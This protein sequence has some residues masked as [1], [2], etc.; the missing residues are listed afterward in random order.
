MSIAWL[1]VLGNGAVGGF[2]TYRLELSTDG[3]AWT[4]VQRGELYF[5]LLRWAREECPRRRCW[6]RIWNEAE[7][8]DTPMV[9]VDQAGLPRGADRFRNPTT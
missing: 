5:P 9:T 2:V 8:A 6:A 1:V 7:A 4:E 3:V